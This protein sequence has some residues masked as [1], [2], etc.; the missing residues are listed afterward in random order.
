MEVA[1]EGGRETESGWTRNRRIEVKTEE[2]KAEDAEAGEPERTA[3]GLR[4]Q[5]GKQCGTSYRIPER[6]GDGVL[7]RDALRC[8]PRRQTGR[9]DVRVYRGKLQTG[10]ARYVFP[11]GKDTTGSTRVA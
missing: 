9:H 8:P 6:T 3:A 2:R 10:T 5:T 4:Y 7:E 11:V 1:R